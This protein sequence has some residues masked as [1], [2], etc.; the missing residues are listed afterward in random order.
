[1]LDEVTVWTDVSGSFRVGERGRQPLNVVVVVRVV[2]SGLRRW[3]MVRLEMA[4]NDVR[5]MVVVR[6][7]K[8]DMFGWQNAEREHREDREQRR[9]PLSTGTHHHGA[10]SAQAKIQSNGRVTQTYVGR[11]AHD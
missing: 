3:S 9:G 7:R 6:S 1:V 10:L 2:N 5:M 11:V 8:V 4:M